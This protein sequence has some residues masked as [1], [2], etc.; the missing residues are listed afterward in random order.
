MGTRC[1]GEPEEWLSSLARAKAKLSEQATIAGVTVVNEAYERVNNAAK[2]CGMASHH[3]LHSKILS[4]FVH[5]TALQVIASSDED[6][7]NLQRDIFFGHG[8]S[9]FYGAF[10]ALEAYNDQVS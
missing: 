4:K 7:T 3:V 2:E 10:V 1:G 8:C 6:E 9:F 5:P